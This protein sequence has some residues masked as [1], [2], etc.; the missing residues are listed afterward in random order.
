MINWDWIKKF[1]S[2]TRVQATIEALDDFVN[3]L[4][5]EI[6]GNVVEPPLFHEMGTSLAE[7]ID[8]MR[9]LGLDIPSAVMHRK[10]QAGWAKLVLREDDASITG[11]IF[12]EMVEEAGSKTRLRQHELAFT[13]AVLEISE[14]AFHKCNLPSVFLYAHPDET[15]RISSL[16][17][18]GFVHT[19][20]RTVEEGGAAY[21]VY[22][23]K[24]PT[25]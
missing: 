1:R 12:L 18:I 3:Q 7:V 23:K 10:R 17:R 6:P 14:F 2:T 4:H 11:Y 20:D 21:R 22:S 15:S 16:E 13:A 9:P 24:K 19:G 8:E 25:N 5:E